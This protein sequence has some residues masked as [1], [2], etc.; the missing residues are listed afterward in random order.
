MEETGVLADL[1]I[2]EVIG[3]TRGVLLMEG[4]WVVPPWAEVNYAV[5][6]WRVEFGELFHEDLDGREGEL[7]RDFDDGRGVVWVLGPF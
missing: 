2:L 5:G 7:K 6:M 4:D 3:S 1:S